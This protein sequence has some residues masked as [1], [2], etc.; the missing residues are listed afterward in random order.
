MLSGVKP[1]PLPS[2]PPIHLPPS[3]RTRGGTAGFTLLEVLIALIIAL[4]AGTA[5]LR[6]VGSTIRATGN[7][8]A[9]DQA[10][11]RAESHLAAAAHFGSLHAGT[12]EG[13]DG[14]GYHWRLRIVPLQTTRLGETGADKPQP[15]SITLYSIVTQISWR[16]GLTTRTV[17]LATEQAGAS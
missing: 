7:T 15:V 14:G 10:I 13:D 6:T 5:F 8:L 9:Y 1:F 11:V 16:E 17:S 4:I 12:W 3:R 2:R